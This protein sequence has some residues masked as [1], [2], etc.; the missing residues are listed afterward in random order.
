MTWIEEKAHAELARVRERSGVCRSSRPFESEGL[1]T[2]V[3]GHAFVNSART[4]T[5]GSRRTR[6]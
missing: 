3:N 1:R 6:A 2:T 4:T 5:S